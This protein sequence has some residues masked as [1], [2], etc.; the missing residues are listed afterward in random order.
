MLV[1]DMTNKELI[2]KLYKE[3]VQ[4]KSKKNIWKEKPNICVIYS[5]RTY[6]Y[7]KPNSDES[8][9]IDLRILKIGIGEGKKR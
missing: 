7:V 5:N 6:D 3:L 9:T 1:N 2:F 4:H 8:D